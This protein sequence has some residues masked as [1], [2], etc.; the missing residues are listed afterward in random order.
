MAAIDV[1]DPSAVRRWCAG[2]VAALASCRAEIDDLNVF[3]VPDGDTGTNLLLTLRAADDAV[4]SDPP[5]D[6]AVTVTSMARGAV[7]GAQGNSGVIVSQVLRGVAEVLARGGDGRPATGPAVAAALARGAE[8]AWA[9]VG[10][11]VEG[12]MLSVISAAAQSAGRA[13]DGLP[14]VVGAAVRGAAA[15]L[16]RTPAQLPVLAAAGVVD[17]GGRG[18]LVLLQALA[19][20]VTS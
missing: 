14:A 4:R 10:A 8:L 7:L 6:L 1:L 9:A 2:A 19:A 13:G 17:A 16:E 12:T 20:V 18:V 11:P 15:A 5:G 3:P